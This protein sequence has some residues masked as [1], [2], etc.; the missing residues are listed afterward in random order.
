MHVE[1]D[2]WMDFLILGVF[3]SWLSLWSCGMEEGGEKYICIVKLMCTELCNLKLSSDIMDS[4]SGIAVGNGGSWILTHS[5][6][7]WLEADVWSVQ[8]F[9]LIIFPYKNRLIYREK[10]LCAVWKCTGTYF[11]CIDLENNPHAFVYRWEGQSGNCVVSFQ[12]PTVGLLVFLLGEVELGLTL[13]RIKR[14]LGMSEFT[15]LFL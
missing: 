3:I 2:I 9:L 15:L 13:F 6:L 8:V 7:L 12:G 5:V 11:S 10:L 1:L 14:C 4:L